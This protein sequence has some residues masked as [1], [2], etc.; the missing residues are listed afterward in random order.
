[1][2][3]QS[4]EAS[5]GHR[6]MVFRCEI[7]GAPAVI[8]IGCHIRQAMQT[9]DASKAGRWF[10]GVDTDGNAVC[11]AEQHKERRHG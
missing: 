9:G 11:A 1:M 4:V 10:C 5:P 8:G 3:V 6:V 7:C 2:P